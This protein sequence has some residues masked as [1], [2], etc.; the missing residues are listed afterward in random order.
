MA[1]EMNAITDRIVMP[2]DFLG[3]VEIVTTERREGNKLILGGYAI[4]YDRNGKEIRR[5]P[6]TAN[7][8]ATLPRRRWWEFWKC[9]REQFSRAERLQREL[10]ESKLPVIGECEECGCKIIS[11]L[12]RR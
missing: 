1:G 6:D 10:N 4:H 3:Y 8:I 9:Y 2:E 5:T 11:P 7:I 12:K